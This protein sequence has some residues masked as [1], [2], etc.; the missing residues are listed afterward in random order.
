M[1]MQEDWEER[2]GLMRWV[3]RVV[4]AERGGEGSVGSM[5]DFQGGLREEG[6]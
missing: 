6:E 4:G 1:G 2:W 5:R 3:K